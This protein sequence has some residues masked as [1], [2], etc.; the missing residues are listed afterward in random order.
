MNNRKFQA[1]HCGETEQRRTFYQVTFMSKSNE[2]YHLLRSHLKSVIE[3]E[4]PLAHC[5]TVNLRTSSLIWFGLQH[6]RRGTCVKSIQDITKTK[7]TS[8]D[9]HFSAYDRNSW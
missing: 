9:I 2:H 8:Q 7:L 6:S 3:P 5:P 4:A 1:I